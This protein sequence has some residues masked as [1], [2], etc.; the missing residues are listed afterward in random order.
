MKMK[1]TMISILAAAVLSVAML[2]ATAFA[3]TGQDAGTADSTQAAAA[4]ESKETETNKETEKTESQMESE[5]SEAVITRQAE[6]ADDSLAHAITEAISPEL[7]QELFPEIDEETIDFLLE[8][9]KLLAMFIPTLHVTVTDSSVKIAV[10]T[11]E[12]E[13]PVQT[14]TVTT[15]GSNLNVRNGASIDF[16]IIGH[17]ANGSEVKV[18]DEKNG[19][20]QIDFPADLAYVCGEYVKLNEI[21]TK[22][23]EEGSSFDIDG[24]DILTFLK[25][26]EKY[27]EQ[28]VVPQVQGLTPDG[29]LTL[30]D[31]YGPATGEG[32]QFV[33]LVS[34]DGNFYYLIIDRDEKGEEN[35]HFLNQVDERDLF[36]LMDEDEAAALQEEM[37]Q[38]E[39]EKQEAEKPQ[40]ATPAEIEPEPEQPEKKSAGSMIG[41]LVVL[42]LVLGGGGAF[43]FLQMK[44]KKKTEAV[45]P[46]PD[47]DYQEEDDSDYGYAD[48]DDD[49]SDEEESDEEPEYDEESEEV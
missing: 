49:T 42:L 8:H 40:E 27:F 38:A 34:R 24:T 31:D 17:L 12:T 44:K 32:Q 39:L 15:Q 37:A 18:L 13:D 33:T 47:A 46:D 45:R 41:A 29:N 43:F 23:T 4:E 48:E 5:E 11:G 14:G 2:P 19:W 26:F 7:V 9:P 6:N 3:F 22:E 28:P 30:V 21:P 35:V 36:S 20:Y 10:D 25:L 16:D 1:R